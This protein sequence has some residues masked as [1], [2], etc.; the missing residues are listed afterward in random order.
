MALFADMV[1]DTMVAQIIGG[2]WGSIG[3]AA[4]FVYKDKMDSGGGTSNGK[5]G[6]PN[7]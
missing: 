5:K 1:S 2:I 4:A 7:G 6:T 3:T